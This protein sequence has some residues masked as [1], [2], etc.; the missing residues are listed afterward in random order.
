METFY[1]DYSSLKPI[2]SFENN[3]NNEKEARDENV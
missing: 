1:Y 2:F 3:E